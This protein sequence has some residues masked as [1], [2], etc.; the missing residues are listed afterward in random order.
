VTAETRDGRARGLSD[1]GGADYDPRRHEVI[2][3]PYPALGRLRERD[4]VHWSPL[5]KGWVL[6]RHADVKLALTDQR[7][8]ADRITPFLDHHRGTTQEELLEL[9]RR[10]G[11]WVVFMDPP[12]HTRIR[13]L[14]NRVV[15]ARVVEGLRP[16]IREIVDG[17]LDAAP[18][19]RVDVIRD[20][21]YPLPLTVIGDLLGVPR[22]DR[23]RLK[24]WS[25]ELA[26]FV[27]SALLT[28]DRYARA[29]ASLREMSEY[30]GR[31]LAERRRAPRDDVLSRLIAAEEGGQGLDQDELVA[32]SILLLFAGHETTTNLI[33]NGLL[34]LLRHPEAAEDW[35][36][37]PAITAPA[38]EELLRYDG[39]SQAMVRIVREDL[40]L[41]GGRLRRGDRVFALVNAANRDP[42]QFAEPDRLDLRRRENRHL[43]F[44]A[45]IHFCLGAPLARLEAQIAFPAILARWPAITLAAD[46][47]EWLD[48]L[49][50]RGVRALPVAIRIAQ[51][52]RAAGSDP[53]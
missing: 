30:F 50:F 33:G 15:T 44:G 4:P 18:G 40:D 25:D 49:V 46:R 3:D 26:S 14:L 53:A 19:D 23:A 13:G 22:E 29:G 36:H 1:G 47:L 9:G 48:S 51:D 28:P 45:G 5:L 31:L 37:H 38:V 52:R 2:A 21:A 39:P 10:L 32:T 34:A 20:L 35:R 17:L 8:S 42:R 16:R 43:A 24:Q 12:R 41:E 11:L 6:T 7:L 27:G